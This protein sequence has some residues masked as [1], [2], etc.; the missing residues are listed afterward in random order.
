[1]LVAV[2]VAPALAL[3]SSSA[4]AASGS[5]VQLQASID[6]VASEWFAAQQRVQQLDDA[7]SRAQQRIAALETR[8]AHMRALA[9]ARAVDIYMATPRRLDTIL[10]SE[11]ALDSARRVD[12]M[13]S[14]NEQNNETFAALAELTSELQLQ[15]KS[16]VRQRDAQR[17]AMDSVARDRASLDTQLEQVRAANV[18]R[19]AA[20]AAAAAATGQRNA[21]SPSSPVVL[22][23]TPTPAARPVAVPAPPS[24]GVYSMHEQPFLVCT[25]TRESDGIYSV[26]SASGIYF[27]AYQF[28]RETWDVT[29]VHAGRSDLVGVLPNTASEYD[30]DN[31]AWALYQWQGNAPWGG[32][33]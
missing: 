9:T 31:L 8:T 6:Q 27:G 18:K 1:V 21:A 26:V 14:A 7:I 29:A 25:R 10:D 11:S 28:S 30:Q 5:T 13:E 33:C 4:H 17:A 19:A 12:L 20:L 15:S 2:S 16:L 24:S 22:V 23:H 3:T 32:R